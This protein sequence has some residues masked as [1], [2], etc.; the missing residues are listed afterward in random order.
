MTPLPF[1]RGKIEELKKLLVKQDAGLREELK[2]LGDYLDSVHPGNDKKE[3][4]GP[5]NKL[6]RFLNKFGEKD[7]QYR[8][9]L[10]K[11]G[12]GA[13]YVQKLGKS[14]NKV[15]GVTG[16]PQIPEFLVK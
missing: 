2:E 6:F 14:Y 16:M 11:A 5:M 7:S 4:T 13:E 3:L 12:K 10:S 1:A 9:L 15:A 8:N